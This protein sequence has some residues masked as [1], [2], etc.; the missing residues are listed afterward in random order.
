MMVKWK[1]EWDSANV[2]AIYE[3]TDGLYANTRAQIWDDDYDHPKGEIKEA[4]EATATLIC[5]AV[6][7]YEK[8]EKRA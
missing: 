4:M 3:P 1:W 7:A 8:G 5:D 6:N 2:I